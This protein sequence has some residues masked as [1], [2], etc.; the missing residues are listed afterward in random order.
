MNRG[1]YQALLSLYRFADAKLFWRLPLPLQRWI[2]E[3]AIDIKQ[4]IF[5]F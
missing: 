3:T 5:I 1:L 4:N 2:Y